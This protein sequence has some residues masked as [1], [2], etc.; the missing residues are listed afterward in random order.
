LGINWDC[1]GEFHTNGKKR[2]LTPR[3]GHAKLFFYILIGKVKLHENLGVGA[4]V[5]RE[6]NKFDTSQGH[7]TRILKL[8]IIYA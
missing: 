2:Y 5:H 8:K 6:S 3:G 1:Q 4:N 7:I